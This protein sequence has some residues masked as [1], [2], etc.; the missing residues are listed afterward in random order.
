MGPLNTAYYKN[1]KP[2]DITLLGL[3]FYNGK[4]IFLR[5]G[6]LWHFTSARTDSLQTHKPAFPASTAVP[7]VGRSIF[8][9]VR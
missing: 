9:I 3:Q 8:P 6:N 2:T 7:C 4:L 1:K 5:F